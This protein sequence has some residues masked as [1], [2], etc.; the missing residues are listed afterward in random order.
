M[1][2][3]TLTTCLAALTLAG[4]AFAADHHGKHGGCHGKKNPAIAA[5]I[6]ADRIMHKGMMIPYTGN[7]DIDF[8]A[9]MIPHHQGAVDM[10]QV[11]L[12][13]GKDPQMRA[14]AQRI[15]IAQE[16]EIG[17]MNQWLSGRQSKWRADNVDALPSS[18]GY[19]QAMEVMH[20]DMAIDY[21]GNADVD[22][23]RGMIPHHQGAVDMAWVLKEHGMDMGLRRFADDIIRSQGQEIRLMQEWLAAQ[24]VPEKKAKH[25]K[26]KM[27]HHGHHASH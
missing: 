27:K 11:E 6:K 5:Y 20:R 19:Q 21:T 24:A 8:V 12:Q 16:T 18:K 10:A 25:A 7:A 22:F 17:Y 3:L 9:G 13:Y 26:K 14:L 2:L 15:I 4:P 23:A 1:R